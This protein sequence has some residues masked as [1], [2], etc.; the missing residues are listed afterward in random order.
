MVAT[1]FYINFY[2]EELKDI[3][4]FNNDIFIILN[5]PN[6]APTPEEV[7]AIEEVIVE[8]LKEYCMFAFVLKDIL[9]KKIDALSLECTKHGYQILSQ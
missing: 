9:S 4:A 5:E 1:G 3:Y 2:R 6:S 8:Y 7:T